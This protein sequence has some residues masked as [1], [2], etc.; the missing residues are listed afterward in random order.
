MCADRLFP[1]LSTQRYPGQVTLRSSRLRLTQTPS[2]RRAGQQ[3]CTQAV[4]VQTD[5]ISDLPQLSA[6]P[7]PDVYS[8][9]G[10]SLPSIHLQSA[11]APPAFLS[12]PPLSSPPSMLST[13]GA[14][15]APPPPPPPPLP[16]PPPPSL[17]P[18]DTQT[19]SPTTQQ[20]CET[21][22]AVLPLAPFSPRFFD[23]S[24]LQTARKKLRK[25]A[26]LDSSHW[27]KGGEN[28]AGQVKPTIV[29]V[30]LE[31]T[32]LSLGK[33]FYADNKML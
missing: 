11:E 14:P 32:A 1:R 3:P 17:P 24:Q 28:H 13:A 20:R 12:L 22:C 9:D 26:S 15:V 33:S 2:R 5:S 8:C 21:E 29:G 4:S 30:L 31:D 19:S 27:R 25:T 16:P 10:T 23:S 6:P 7:P 18:T